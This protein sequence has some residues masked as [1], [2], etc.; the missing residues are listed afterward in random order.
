MAGYPGKIKADY[1]ALKRAGVPG[2]D[3]YRGPGT[4]HVF[5][6][7]RLVKYACEH[8]GTVN[9]LELRSQGAYQRGYCKGRKCRKVT[10]QERVR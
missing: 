3:G 5:D 9:R 4:T 7:A 6:G 10:N 8:C 2:S 1:A